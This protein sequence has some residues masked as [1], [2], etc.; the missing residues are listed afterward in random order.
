MHEELT[1]RQTYLKRR[2]RLQGKI[3]N[4]LV[5]VMGISALVAALILTGIIKFPYYNSFNKVEHYA[6]KGT[7]VCIAKDTKSV[8]LVGVPVKVFNGTSRA[9]LA[10]KVGQALAAAGLEFKEKANYTG[11]FYGSVRIVTDENHLVQAYSLARLFDD[12]GV[13]YDPDITDSLH[14]IVGDSFLEMKD[15]EVLKVLAKDTQESLEPLPKC[16]P[17]SPARS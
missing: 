8:S 2:Q 1:P 6:E 13:I 14:V 7:S 17:L 11:V 4:L 3:F 15:V 16:L 12:A 9:G 5:A 10:D